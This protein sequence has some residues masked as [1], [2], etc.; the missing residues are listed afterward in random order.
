MLLGHDFDGTVDKWSYSFDKRNRRQV[1]PRRS[2]SI[3]YNTMDLYY[4]LVQLSRLGLIEEMIMVSIELG[5]KHT[6]VVINDK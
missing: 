4:A 6:G 2:C 1:A 3:L 5:R